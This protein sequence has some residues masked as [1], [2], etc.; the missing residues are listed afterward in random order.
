LAWQRF[1]I[2]LLPN[3]LTAFEKTTWKFSYLWLFNFF[4]L[5]GFYQIFISCLVSLFLI[6]HWGSLN[7]NNPH[8]LIYLNTW[9]PVAQ[10]VWEGL[11]DIALLKEVY[12]GA[13][14]FPEAQA[15]SSA[16]IFSVLCLRCES[17]GGA[18]VPCLLVWFLPW[19]PWTLSFWTWKPQIS[20]FFSMNYLDH[21][22]FF[23]FLLLYFFLHF[24]W[25][26][27]PGFPSA[28]PLSY[29]SLT[30][31]S[32]RVLHHPTKHSHPIII[33]SWDFHRTK[34]LPSHW[35]QIKLSSAT[36]AAGAMGPAMCILVLVV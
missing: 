35:C 4:S 27:L 9:S 24:K 21:G 18:L 6:H 23:K 16:S 1:V 22:F 14:R 36:Y 8:R 32:K 17:P 5:T 28:N 11:G 10:T 13:V 26:P 25:Y 12:H 31:V 15:I 20:F 33:L 34:G 30:P 19:W 7:N 29:P 3:Y 2:P